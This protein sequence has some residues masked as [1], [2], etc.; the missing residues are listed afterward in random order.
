MGRITSYLNLSSFGRFQGFKRLCFGLLT[1]PWL[2][3]CVS[4]GPYCAEEP[5]EIA[6]LKT[7]VAPS[8][9]TGEQFLARVVGSYPLVFK[10]HDRGGDPQRVAFEPK[11]AGVKGSMV[12][13][14][15]GGKF[16]YVKSTEVPCEGAGCPDIGLMC[17]NRFEA[18]VMVELRSEDGAFQERWPVTVYAEDR[19][20][21]SSAQARVRF[22]RRLDPEG[23]SGR[24]RVLNVAPPAGDRLLS[25]KMELSA[26]F[27][28]GKLEFAQL[29][30]HV[31]SGNQRAL[32]QFREVHYD[33]VAQ[34]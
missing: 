31:E 10:A 13:S 19:P 30:S 6:D 27:V 26:R 8:G 11:S 21:L 2:G 24:F 28:A 15:K 17:E 3:A 22:E 7:P 12:I 1:L 14:Y 33:L 5:K 16:R 18:E 32:S 20:E 9:M 23:F 29:S 25:H 34:P 4:T